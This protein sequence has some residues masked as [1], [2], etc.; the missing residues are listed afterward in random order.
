MRGLPH[1]S[2]GQDSAAF[3]HSLIDT[4]GLQQVAAAGALVAI[5]H[6]EGLL[7]SSSAQGPAPEG[8][9]RA[10]SPCTGCMAALRLHLKVRTGVT[11]VV[12]RAR[13]MAPG[14]QSS[15]GPHAQGLHCS[16]NT[17]R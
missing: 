5:L 9:H 16:S 7:G 6:K 13:L 8:Q 4:S 11:A 15:P 12:N 14:G 10:I 1:H 2:A 3:L 17:W